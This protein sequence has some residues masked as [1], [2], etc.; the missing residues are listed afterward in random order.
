MGDPSIS[1]G[2]MYAFFQ[3]DRKIEDG[4]VN[5]KN[6]WNMLASS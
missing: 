3:R 1:I 4:F 6:P 5:R 2:T